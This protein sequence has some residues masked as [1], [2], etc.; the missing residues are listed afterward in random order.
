[1]RR[2]VVAVAGALSIISATPAGATPTF[3]L[4]FVNGTSLQAQAAFVEAA[5]YWRT[6]LT[7]SVTINLT[8]GTGTLGSGILASTGAA[9]GTYSYSNVR[10]A[11]AAD[12]T[13][14]LDATAVANLP[15]GS[16]LS[17]YINRTSEVSGSA[18]PYVDSTGANNDTIW[19]TSANA[20]ALGL[21]TTGVI[22]PSA[23]GST[24]DG[25]IVFSN[26]FTYDYDRSNNIAGNAYD[27]VGMAT[28]EIGHALGFVSG[29]DILDINA[30]P[31]NPSGPFAADQF[32]FVSPLDL[33]RCSGASVSAGADIDWTADNR[34]KDFSVD[35]CATPLGIFANGVNF[36]DGQQ[37]SHWKDN[38]NLG[39]M[40]PTVAPGELMTISSRDL[41]ALDVIG[42][43]VNV[44]EPATLGL[45]ATAV[46]GLV[47]LR[48]KGPPVP[49]SA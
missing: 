11:L 8:V 2:I 14:S 5:N 1:M 49:P 9:F 48:R 6:Y 28:H 44:P 17:L 26:A 42:W 24:C 25:Y 16:S 19:M 38:L 3:N 23:C 39:I 36:G 22:N 21:D 20:K 40:D 46:L 13:S 47:R 35:G 18:T 27:F 10:T 33:Y 37:A 12:S 41:Q 30:P 32:T 31:A 43:D 34:V 45:F 29:V 7:D 15:T 4:T